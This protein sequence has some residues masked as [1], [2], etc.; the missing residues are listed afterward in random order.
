MS[1]VAQTFR[2][3]EWIVIDGGSADGS[4]EVME[5]YA[6]RITY[7]VSEPDGGIYEAMNKGIR[8]S[9]GEYLLFL[10]SG[11]C[12]HDAGVLS[13]VAPLL[14]GADFYIGRERRDG[15]TVVCDV[16]TAEKTYEQAVYNFIPHQSTFIRRTVFDRYGFYREDLRVV[17]DWW[18]FIN[19]I[20]LGDASVENLHFLISDFEGNGIGANV[21]LAT[22]ERGRM[23][24]AVPRIAYAMDFYKNNHDIV[25][26]LRSSRF[27]FFLFRV[28]YFF[29][30][31]LHKT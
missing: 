23:L 13:A 12:L 22:A 21:L 26:A 20:V 28:Y 14:R 31:K 18:H 5:Q 10:N 3:F 27:A 2:D 24:S 11:D 4:R 6:D 7:G 19:A 16:T 1:V 15:M 25:V 29:W 17:S 30:R 8:A 9:H